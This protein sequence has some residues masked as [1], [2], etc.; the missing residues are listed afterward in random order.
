MALRP[1]LAWYRPL[2]SS[3]ISRVSNYPP[4]SGQPFHNAGANLRPRDCLAS[5]RRTKAKCVCRDSGDN[6]AEQ[7]QCECNMSR[8]PWPPWSLWQCRV[9]TAS[10]LPAEVASLLSLNFSRPR[11]RPQQAGG[12]APLDTAPPRDFSWTFTPIHY[13]TLSKYL[14]LNL[15]I[16]LRISLFF[17]NT[18]HQ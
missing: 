4:A 6:G 7:S 16:F 3:N 15:S 17:L 18:H 13:A 2:A 9:L 5:T 14:G 10:L 8:A 1:R 11:R 12:R